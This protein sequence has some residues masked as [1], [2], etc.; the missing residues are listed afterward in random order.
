MLDGKVAIVTGAANGLGREE[1]LE[2]A[3]NGARVIV[4]DLGVGRDGMGRDTTAADAVVSEIRDSGG[5]AAAHFGDVADWNDAHG[6]I[7]AAVTTFGG[8]DILVNNAGFCRDKMIFNMSEEEFDSV[9]RV[10]VKGNFCTLKFASMY[11]REQAKAKG[12][13]VY[14]RVVGTSSEAFLFCSVG[15]PNYAAGK[16]GITA[17]TLS[18]GQA[19]LKYGVTSNVICPRART[20]MTDVGMLA[21]MFAKPDEGFDTF[22]PANIAPFVA[23]LSSPAAENISGQVFIVCGDEVSI[24]GRPDIANPE[25]SFKNEGKW[26]LN[27]LDGQL[28]PYF[29]KREL[30]EGYA[31]Q[32]S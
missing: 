26:T 23:Y 3:R 19:L 4:N 16:A 18:T 8:L 31:V 2:L 32:G 20:R 15:Q 17:L 10:H 28:G 1:A 30:G 13:Q 7:E 29:A 27:Q 25:R 24:V 21:P 11:W 6:L 5:E 22:D 12:G 9:L 14:G